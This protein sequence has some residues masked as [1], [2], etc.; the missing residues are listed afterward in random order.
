MLVRYAR[1]HFDVANV[2]GRVS[3]ALAEES[4]GIVVH[5]LLEGGWMITLGKSNVDSQL[6]QDV[7]KQRVSRPVKLRDRDDVLAVPRYVQNG[8]VQRR[9]TAA[10][11]ECSHS[12]FKRGDA[13]FEYVAGR[14]TDSAVTVSLDLEIEQSR[15]VLSAVEGVGYG[16]IDR[17]GDRL[18][19]R[20]GLVATVDGNG[21]VPHPYR[22]PE[23]PQEFLLATLI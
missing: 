12:A 15:T 1:Q 3:N 17:N 5:Q 11:S 7:R 2:T 21:F 4:P 9:L 8:V 10:D 16:L 18:G 19:R 23:R 13:P 14:V 22:S 20:I 6:G